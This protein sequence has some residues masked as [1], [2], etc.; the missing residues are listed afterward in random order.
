[1]SFRCSS[2]LVGPAT[3][4]THPVPFQFSITSARRKSSPPAPHREGGLRNGG[5]GPIGTECATR[6]ARRAPARIRRAHSSKSASRW[7][8]GRRAIA[9]GVPAAG[10]RRGRAAACN[11]L[12]P[13]MFRF[14]PPPYRTISTRGP[15][16]LVAQSSNLTLNGAHLLTHPGQHLAHEPKAEEDDAGDHEHHD[17]VEERPKS[18]VRGTVPQIERDAAHEQS[19]QEWH[20]SDDPEE[21]HGLAAE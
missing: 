2:R 10:V 17:Q 21:Q 3:A 5:D 12:I 8:L 7:R 13:T 18:D 4:G 16:L 1:M 11:R 9:T 15:F 6:G 14:A 20:R 19:Q